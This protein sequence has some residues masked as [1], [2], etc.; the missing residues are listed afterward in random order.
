MAEAENISFGT[1][2]YSR[3]QWINEIGDGTYGQVFKA[4]DSE[5]GEIVAMKKTK[6]DVSSIQ[7][8]V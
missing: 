5:T 4:R 7:D 1:S 8:K 6:L 3:Y 2:N